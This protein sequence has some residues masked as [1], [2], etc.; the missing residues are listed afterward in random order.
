VIRGTFWKL[1]YKNRKWINLSMVKMV[2]Q[3]KR[4]KWLAKL[5]K[6][7]EQLS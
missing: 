3:A 5:G 1:G 7:F 2:S 4:A 6:R